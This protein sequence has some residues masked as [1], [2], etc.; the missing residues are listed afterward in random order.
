MEL[1]DELIADI[2]GQSVNLT[3]VLIKTKVLAFKLKNEDLSKWIEYELNGYPNG[4]LPDYR[5][6]HCQVIGHMSNGFREVKNYPIPI[7]FLDKKLLESITTVRLNQS[8]STL[9]GLTNENK[10]GMVISPE[11]YPYLSKGLDSGF[12]IQYARREIDNAQIAQTNTAIRS[13]LLD[14]LLKLSDEVGDKRDLKTFT[15]GKD[16]DRVASIFHSAIFG[17]NTTI[18]VGDNNTQSISDSYNVYRNFEK[19]KKQLVE[20]GLTD[21]DVEELRLIIDDDNAN[22]VEHRF[23]D[24]V[25]NW[26]SKSLQKTMDGS[27]TI[28]LGVAANLLSDVVSAYY[29]WK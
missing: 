20:M 18:I 19:L 12:V 16:K 24:K 6:L 15:V 21:S 11:F 13:K 22:Q 14:F 27:W 3:D 23:G 10:L 26:I 25:K 7:Q 5:I 4:N 17:N 2:T 1:I 9:E 28:G 29:G 8:V